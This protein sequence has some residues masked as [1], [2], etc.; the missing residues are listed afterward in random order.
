MAEY[1]LLDEDG[2]VIN[3]ILADEQFIKTLPDLIADVNVDTGTLTF[4]RAV[5]LTDGD[6]EQGVGIGWHHA[7]DDWQ[8]P[9]PPPVAAE[10]PVTEDVRVQVAAI[11]DA[12]QPAADKIDALVAL[13]Q[14]ASN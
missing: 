3:V 8:R 9:T 1:A 14:D 5:E 11:V 12:D 13:I 10:P 7:T 4:D 2:T 6:R